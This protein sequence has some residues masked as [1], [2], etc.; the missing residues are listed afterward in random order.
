MRFKYAFNVL[1]ALKDAGYTT[2][3]I[4]K[5]KI[6]AEGTLTKL[7][8]GIMVS[9]DQIGIICDLLQCAPWDLIEYIPGNDSDAS[10]DTD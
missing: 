7:R 5:E 6:L 4:R 1:D 10:Q 8:S 9:L 3:K 2:Y